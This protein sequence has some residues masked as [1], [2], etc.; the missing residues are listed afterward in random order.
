MLLIQTSSN[1]NI[2]V[3]IQMRMDLL[4]HT[5]QSSWWGIAEA[6]QLTLACRASLCCVCMRSGK[7]WKFAPWLSV[8]S[9]GIWARYC[10]CCCYY[11]CICFSR[12]YWSAVD[13]Q[14]CV[15]FRCTTVILLHTHMH[16]HTH[17]YIYSFFFRFLIWVLEG[18][19][20]HFQ[21]DKDLLG[22][23]RV[24][25]SSSSFETPFPVCMCSLA[26]P[27]VE[28]AARGVFL[29]LMAIFHAAFN[30]DLLRT[31][32]GLTLCSWDKSKLFMGWRRSRRLIALFL[33]VFVFSSLN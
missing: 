3:L 28:C 5:S 14:C 16:T 25:P 29:C 6:T 22:A 26:H 32:L 11:T 20:A 2:L 30:L 23:R 18:G 27:H 1:A 8:A 10:Y 21:R 24:R 33:V 15:S 13:L 17:I 7:T 9:Y 4:T 19:C 31:H 12:F